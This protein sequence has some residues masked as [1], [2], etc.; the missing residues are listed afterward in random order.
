MEENNLEKEVSF[1]YVL[2]WREKCAHASAFRQQALN[3]EHD[4]GSDGCDYEWDRK[5]DRC[6]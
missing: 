3:V 1:H 6:L 2:L 5:S 4:A